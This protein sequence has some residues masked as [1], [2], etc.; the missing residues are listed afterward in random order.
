MREVRVHNDDIVSCDEL[1]AV[2]VC[3]SKTE[4]AGA[5]FEEDMGRVG[6]CKLVRDDLGA[7]WGAVVDDD[8]FPIKV[9]L[10][11]GPVQQPGNDWEVAS[12]IVC[13]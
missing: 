12:L 8:E 3:R 7:V 2:Y 1:Q 4:L 5:R 11:E 6:F 9:L 13:R 10:G